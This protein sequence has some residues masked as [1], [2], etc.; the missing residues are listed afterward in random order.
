VQIANLQV[1]DKF[2]QKFSDSRSALERWIELAEAATWTKLLDVQNTFPSA[3]DVKGH[4]VFNIRGNNYRLITAINYD[5]QQVILLSILTHAE[6][7]RMDFRK[8]GKRN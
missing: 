2:T 7:D 6:Y 4:I 8:K 5:T 3:E 1:V